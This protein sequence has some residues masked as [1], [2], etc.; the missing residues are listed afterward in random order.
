MVTPGGDPTATNTLIETEDQYQASRRQYYYVVQ[1]A[2]SGRKRVIVRA[3]GRE[4][5]LFWGETIILLTYIHTHHIFTYDGRDIRR[6]YRMFAQ[7]VNK[8]VNRFGF[9]LTGSSQLV[10]Q[11]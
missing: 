2:T 1:A 6:Q 10:P 9:G 7:R 8:A 5:E 11:S 3:A 4:P